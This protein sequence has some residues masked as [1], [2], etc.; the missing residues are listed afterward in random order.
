MGEAQVDLR[1][2][3]NLLKAVE[4]LAPKWQP[5]PITMITQAVGKMLQDHVTLDP[6]C[7]DRLY[8]NAS[9]PMLQTGGGVSS[10]FRKH[11]GTLVASTKLMAPMSTDF[12]KRIHLFTRREGLEIEAINAI[13]SKGAIMCTS[14]G[15]L[16]SFWRSV[17]F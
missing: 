11:R 1:S 6:D 12:V 8:L 4:S 14:C 16:S 3:L 2:G 7:I 13:F 17:R 5:E 9:Q 15:F 10:F